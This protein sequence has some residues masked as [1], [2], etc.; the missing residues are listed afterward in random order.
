M[1]VLPTPGSPS[2]TGLFLVRRERIWI[3]RSISSSRPMTASSLPS[4]ASS[5][6]SR[7]KAS[8][9]GVLLLPPPPPP[10][11]ESL[12]RRFVVV[13][14]AGVGAEELE[15]LLA[16][17]LELDA[18]VQEHLAAMPSFSLIRPSSRCSVPM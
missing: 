6:R 13:L 11:S 14:V 9:A 15:H 3:T 8:S 10:D 12:D 16:H 2:S 4:R 5:V 7:P 17:V 1:A 18:E